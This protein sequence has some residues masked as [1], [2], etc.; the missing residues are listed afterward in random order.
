M[1]IGTNEPIENAYS[2]FEAFYSLSVVE[3]HS[4]IQYSS[5]DGK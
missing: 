3:G 1:N 4:L 2:G 5:R